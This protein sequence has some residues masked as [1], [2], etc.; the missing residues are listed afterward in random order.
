MR[1]I[2][3][4]TAS[5]V[6]DKAAAVGVKT[7]DTVKSKV[8]EQ[9]SPQ[10]R[11]KQEQSPESYA[12]DQVTETGERAVEDVAVVG[13]KAVKSTVRKVKDKLK[14]KRTEEQRAEE[15]PGAERSETPNSTEAE[16]PDT[17]AAESSQPGSDSAP[18]SSEEKP[19]NLTERT[20]EKNDVSKKESSSKETSETGARQK[21]DSKKPKEA[22]YS[23]EKASE[24]SSKKLGSEQPSQNPKQKS[25]SKK[26]TGDGKSETPAE[27]GASADNAHGSKIKQ[28]TATEPKTGVRVEREK[29]EIRR[30]TPEQTAIKERTRSAPKEAFKSETEVVEREIR[31]RTK[32]KS[33]PK[34]RGQR[35]IKTAGTRANEIRVVGSSHR[36]KE[37]QSGTKKT[38]KTAD[39]AVKN[40]ERTAKATKKAAE[41]SAKAAKRSEEAARQTAKVAVRITKAAIKATIEGIKAAIAAAKELIAAA[42][43]GSPVAIAIIIILALAA[44]IG[45][46]CF[47]I[48]LL[49]D[50]STGTQVTI[51]EAI[52]QLTTEHYTHLTNLK[53]GYDYDSM[54]T[55]DGSMTINWREVLSVYAVKTTTSTDNAYEVATLN[56]IKMDLLRDVID[57][58]NQITAVVV[59][60]VVAETVTQTDES[61]NTT[62]TTKYVTKNVL[63][64]TI[65][66]LSAD[67]IAEMY[68]FTDEQ[69]EQLTELLSDKYDDLWKEL[70][71]SA[72]ATGDIL[73]TNSTYIP[74]DIFAWPLVVVAAQWH[75][76]YGYYVKIQHNDTFATLYRH[77]SALHVSAGQQVKQGQIV[78]D[79]GHTGYATGPHVHF[80]VY[81]NGTRVDAMQYFN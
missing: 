53:S 79:V 68:H 30:K 25:Q 54:E 26:T 13:K 15:M 36:A 5:A 21:Q 62:T 8:E 66:S 76:S 58:M 2:K 31:P 81:I 29:K 19:Q 71:G 61:G 9:F 80:E 1:T 59:P 4:H 75:D 69:K 55:T 35:T 22:K 40:A 70:I 44:A 41:A 60:T 39:K 52:P 77:C 74:T 43:A 48:F 28:K 14:E 11:R 24:S 37:V 46:S 49:N 64:V 12:S 38:I 65:I 16:Q 45:G 6:K 56:D 78:A 50:E 51:S 63:H 73:I 27:K 23:K 18:V 67:Q 72:G 3:E 33:M 17:P 10:Q 7:K 34:Q 20:A 42:A 32:Q 57:D 47:G